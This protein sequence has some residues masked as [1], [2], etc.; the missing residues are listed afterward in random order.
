MMKKLMCLLLAAALVFTLAACG[1]TE[2]GGDGQWTREGYFTDE[3]DHLLSITRMDDVDEPGWYVGCQLGEDLMEDSWDGM[4][5]AE[6][7]SLRGALPSSGSQADLTVTIT[8]EGDSGVQLAVEGG[9]TYHF[10]P[11]DLPQAT[12]IVTIN[13]DGRGNIDYA[14][15]E[16][17]PEIDPDYP[18]QSAQ[19]NLAEPTVHTFV[20]WPQPG[21][22]FVKWT[23]NGEDFSTEP[24]ITVELDESADFIA[25]FAEDPDWQDPLTEY[26]GEY[27]C[28]RAH[29]TVESTGDGDAWI[30]VEWGSS[31]AELARWNIYGRLDPETMTVAYS[32]CTRQDVVYNEQGEITSEDVVSED[33]SGS[34]V[35]HPDGTFT[36]HDDQAD[37][38]GD[39]VFQPLPAE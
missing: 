35:F 36:W 3:N 33:N 27:Q 24:Q 5:A 30:T 9:E 14:E 15:G 21:S 16:E 32:N 23:R 13:V 4:L 19:I 26:V 28:D 37:H 6:G 17:A 8:E 7:S 1:G 18:Y 12:I 29:A 38:E 11:M 25:V 39:L 34:V 10:L 22:L 20:A 2:P 31:A